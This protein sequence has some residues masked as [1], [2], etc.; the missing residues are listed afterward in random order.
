MAEHAFAPGD[1]VLLNDPYRG[2]TISP[3]SRS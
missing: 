1:A 2:G 3:T